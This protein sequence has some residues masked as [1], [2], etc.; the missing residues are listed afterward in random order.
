MGRRLR[1]NAG[2]DNSEKNGPV[3]VR[4]MNRP[5][6]GWTEDDAKRLLWQGYADE[7]VAFV[8]GYALEWVKA[9][10]EKAPPKPL[11]DA[12]MERGRKKL[13]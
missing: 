11:Q 8:T 10:R 2:T 6:A 5:K 7:Q 13:P 3:T 4:Q 12:L 9:Q 1:A